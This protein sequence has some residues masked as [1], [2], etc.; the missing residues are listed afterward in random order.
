MISEIKK[1][2]LIIE[3]KPPEL[4]KVIKKVKKNIFNLA[5]GN[6]NSRSSYK[7]NERNTFGQQ[8]S[9]EYHTHT[10]NSHP[11]INNSNNNNN[12]VNTNNT[13]HEK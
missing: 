7:S 4:E 10:T 6:K 8:Q 3:D 12:P 11:V 9:Q 13:H 2:E 5:L 1:N